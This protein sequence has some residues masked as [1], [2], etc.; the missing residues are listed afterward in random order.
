MEEAGARIKVGGC[1]CVEEHVFAQQGR[2]GGKPKPRHEVNV[3]L[4]ADLGGSRTSLPPVRSLESHIGFSWV[5]VGDLGSIDLR[6]GHHTKEIVRAAHRKSST[7][8][9]SH[10]P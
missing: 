5:A 9:R 6:P 4:M 10:T 8:F 3:L 1:L 7:Q 2:K